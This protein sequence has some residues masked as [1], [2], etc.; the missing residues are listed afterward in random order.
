MQFILVQSSL[1]QFNPAWFSSV[2]FSSVQLGSN[3]L[4]QGANH[5]ASFSS[6]MII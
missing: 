6:K 4:L 5:T 3:F 2:Q 1:V